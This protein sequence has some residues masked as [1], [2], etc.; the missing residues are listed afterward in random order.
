MILVTTPT[1]K[2]G[3]LITKGL[4]EKGHQVKV[5]ARHPS[6]IP[7]ELQPKIQIAEGS[8]LDLD[9]FKMALRGCNSLY[10]CIPETNTQ[11]NVFSYYEHF[12]SIAQNAIKAS[13]VERVVFVSG[14]GKGTVL[15]AGISSA[16]LGLFLLMHIV[17]AV[18][19]CF[20]FLSQL[21]LHNFLRWFS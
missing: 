20:Y 11:A 4:I 5:L 19:Q 12:A 9:S 10:F 3:S 13:Q 18:D 16:L 17:Q 14:G 2:T 21:H 15:N 1:G 6:K 8:L 7:T